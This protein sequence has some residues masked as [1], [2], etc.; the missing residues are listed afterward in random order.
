MRINQ[1]LFAAANEVA[2]FETQELEGR[3]IEL[4]YMDEF[5][6]VK[7]EFLLGKG[8]FAVWS[9]VDGVNYRLFIERGYHEAVGELYSK[10]VNKIWTDFWDRTDKISKRFTF[11]MI[12]PLMGILVV[13]CVLSF[14]LAEQLKGVMQWVIIGV[15]IGLFF[16]MLLFNF[17]T[18]KKITKEN[19]ASR[20]LI[21]KHLG[22]EHF[23]EVIETQKNYMDSYFD[24]LYQNN[25]ENL[26]EENTEDAPVVAAIESDTVEEVKDEEVKEEATEEKVEETKEEVKEEVK[27]EA[28][29]QVKEVTEEVTTEE[30]NK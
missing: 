19:I 8:Q 15:L 2:P 14:V 11:G 12:Y 9:S 30:E 1:K 3:K 17:L 29:V 28:E 7:E 20:D 21:I 16:V 13:M 24:S 27:P 22:E 23:D 25:E 18:K 26:D 5:T 10:E 4:Y 6:G